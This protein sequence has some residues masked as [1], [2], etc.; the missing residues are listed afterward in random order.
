MATLRNVWI[1]AVQCTFVRV[2]DHAPLAERLETWTVPGLNGIG[3]IKAGL[4][5]SR[6]Q[7]VAQIKGTALETTVWETALRALQGSIV[8]ITDD[9]GTVHYSILMEEV[10]PQAR[11]AESG[12]GGC[13]GQVSISGRYTA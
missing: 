10:V 4:S 7:C 1:G 11:R 3:A 12:Y 2:A 5:D 13:H 8:N 9:W 6:F